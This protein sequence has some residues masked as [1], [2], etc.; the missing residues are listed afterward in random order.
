[1][2]RNQIYKHIHTLAV[3]L[4]IIAGVASFILI[5]V[6]ANLESAKPLAYIPVLLVSA[7]IS[8]ILIEGFSILVED[9][10]MRLDD[11]WKTE[12]NNDVNN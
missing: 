1:M 3:I 5:F 11:K 12:S 4:V 8:Y 7:T 2:E 6:A 9:A 10:T